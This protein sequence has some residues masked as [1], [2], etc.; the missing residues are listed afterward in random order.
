[1]AQ[2]ARAMVPDGSIDPV[3]VVEAQA[4]GALRT[5]VTRIL[6]LSATSAAFANQAATSG[7]LDVRVAACLRRP[8]SGTRNIA[9]A[10]SRSRMVRLAE[11]FLRRSS[12]SAVSVAQLSAVVGVSERTLRSAFS[13]VYTTSPKR[14]IKLWQLHRVRR[15]LRSAEGRHVTVTAVAL[16]NGF[17]ELG[18]FAG[19]Y[20]ALFGEAPS[21]TLGAVRRAN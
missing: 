19:E 10:S 4:V 1:M 17:S 14:Y 15:A 21:Q 7:L 5:L 2:F 11:D 13:E 18:R 16:S 3:A 12:G 20:K 9:E 8:V 6:R